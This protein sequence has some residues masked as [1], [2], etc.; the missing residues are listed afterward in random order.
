MFSTQIARAVSIEREATLPRLPLDQALAGLA[1]RFSRQA[2]PTPRVASLPQFAGYHAGQLADLERHAELVVVPAGTVIETAGA[3]SSQAV[4]ITRG[5]VV[6]TN[7]DGVAA[8]RRGA[9]HHLA[10]AVLTG[11]PAGL[12]VTAVTDIEAV[13]VHASAIRAAARDLPGLTEVLTAEP[14]PAS[15][16]LASARLPAPAALASLAA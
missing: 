12:T 5:Q 16:E 8:G 6:V 2:R 1:G 3:R 11:G 14:S 9:G 7:G 15:L 10:S 13:V 4:F